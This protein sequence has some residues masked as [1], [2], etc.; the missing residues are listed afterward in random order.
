[1]T[2]CYCY[3]PTSGPIYAHYIHLK[4]WIAFFISSL[5]FG[6]FSPSQI[7]NCLCFNYYVNWIHNVLTE[8]V[9]CVVQV[10][11]RSYSS[12]PFK[13]H[14]IIFLRALFHPKV[15]VKWRGPCI[16]FYFHHFFFFFRNPFQIA[17]ELS[18][19]SIQHETE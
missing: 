19:V 6:R 5:P 14:G 8:C 12:D 3:G 7:K 1:M 2:I 18:I 17:P 16:T 10:Q 15:V 11:Y 4:L 13:M 9:L